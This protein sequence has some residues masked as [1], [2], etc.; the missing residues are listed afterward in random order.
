LIIILRVFQNIVK[1][2]FWKILLEP[3]SKPFEKILLQNLLPMVPV[4]FSF[5]TNNQM[6]GSLSANVPK[7]NTLL[8]SM[9]APLNM[10]NNA[11]KSGLNIVNTGLN[12]GLNAVNNVAKN[13]FSVANSAVNNALNNL[14]LNTASNMG[15]NAAN[16][17]G[18]GEWS[19]LIILGVCIAIF[20]TVYVIF[21]TQIDK[22]YQDVKEIVMG[23]FGPTQ[24]QPPAFPDGQPPAAPID[25][26]D[27]GITDLEKDIEKDLKK[28]EV[29]VEKILP[30][31]AM[32]G[33]KEVFNVSSNRYTFYDAQPLCKAL[34]AELATYDQVKEA[35]AKGADWC[36]Y[37]WVDGQMAVYPTSDETYAKLQGGPEEQRMACG[38]P[39][40]NGGY[41]D[42]PE[43]RFGVNCY[44][45]KPP[46]SKHDAED[47]SKGAP[48]SPD[49][50][51]FDKKVNQ[52][53]NEADTIGINPFNS[54]QWN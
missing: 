27:K 26:V 52:Y 40:V 2:I 4:I 18:M 8:N 35:W 17:T 33:G 32:T 48:I 54:H 22:L 14:G 49:A 31:G 10:V 16:M 29:N 21:Q 5:L 23:F 47:M 25:Q 6:N 11:A 50:L 7:N 39:G 12:T 42:N 19:A 1:T 3:S 45:A 13:T 37:G 30:G 53:K 15:S 34:G 43:M 20:I 24:P 51:A 28:A 46:K 36:N 41:F 38:R 9:I 44:G